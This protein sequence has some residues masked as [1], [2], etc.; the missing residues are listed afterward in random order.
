MYNI[1]TILAHP[2]KTQLR[3]MS[4]V[5]RNQSNGNAR[6]EIMAT[7]EDPENLYQSIF[8]F[9]PD[10]IIMDSNLLTPCINVLAGKCDIIIITEDRSFTDSSNIHCAYVP[11]QPPELVTQALNL[12]AIITEEDY[13]S[14]EAQIF[15][16]LRS[17]GLPQKYCS[18]IDA[19][20]YENRILTRNGVT[21]FAQRKRVLDSIANGSL[22]LERA[23]QKHIDTGFDPKASYN[24]SAMRLVED[25]GDIQAESIFAPVGNGQQF[26]APAQAPYAQP[27][28]QPSAPRQPSNIQPSVQ[29]QNTAQPTHASAQNPGQPRATAQNTPLLKQQVFDSM[30]ASGGIP[31]RECHGSTPGMQDI[32]PQ[33]GNDDP[34]VLSVNDE[35]HLEFLRSPTKTQYVVGEKIKREDLLVKLIEADGSFILV[36]D[37]ELSP[38]GTLTQEDKQVTIRY[39]GLVL[40]YPITVVDKMLLAVVINTMPKKLDYICGTKELDLSGGTLAVFFSDSTNTQIEITQDMIEGFDGNRIGRQIVNICYRDQKLPMQITIRP[41]NITK[42]E[43]ISQPSRRNYTE[44]ERLDTTGLVLCVTYDNDEK[45]YVTD[46]ECPEIK[47]QKDQAVVQ[48]DYKGHIFP[49]FVHVC[50][51]VLTG[52]RME[53]LP[54]KL[55]YLEKRD[56]LEVTGGQVARLMSNGEVEIVPLELRMVSGFNNQRVGKCRVAV[57]LDDFQCFFDVEIVGREVAKL[58]VVRKPHKTT[59][60]EQEPFEPE[61]MEIKAQYNNNTFERVEVYEYEPRVLDCGTTAVTIS[62]GGKT[63][64]VPVQVQ[65]RMVESISIA[66]MP[67]KMHFKEGR[68][69]LDVSGGKLLVIYNN[70]SADTIDMYE[71]MVEGFDN[72][73]AGDNLLTVRLQDKETQYHVVIDPKV[74]IGISIT[75][76]PDKV[77]YQKG[78]IPDLDGMKLLG[79]YDNSSMSEIQHYAYQPNGALQLDDTAIIVSYMD[80]VAIVPI[81][82]VEEI[83]APEPVIEAAP[84]E[85]EEEVLP[86]IPVEEPVVPTDSLSESSRETETDED[87]IDNLEI[88]IEPEEKNHIEP[89]LVIEADDPPLDVSV[90]EDSSE[91]KQDDEDISEDRAGEIESQDPVFDDEINQEADAETNEPQA[92]TR[93][94]RFYAGTGN[95]RFKSDEGN[96]RLFE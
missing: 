25:L 49:V 54:E 22:P 6:I 70:G 20:C 35:R 73:K 39:D 50:S 59:Y 32:L 56:M 15:A 89:E 81:T 21:P 58:E 12:F 51:C 31:L 44:G 61:G 18:A 4:G 96:Y 33:G 63:A 68:E 24:P 86:I 3:I 94:V 80:K 10:L 64:E 83:E 26:T 60:F 46:Y 17:L 29:A 36:R 95:L 79:F 48:M 66:K 78:D 84:I 45:E 74:L 38:S 62:F 8:R 9:A 23:K 14:R 40:S 87:S 82:V 52:I 91:T 90:P 19:F 75:K 34:A 57:N 41:K 11:V 53:T 47:V 43:V 30:G 28:N 77:T 67:D 85:P 65:M 7:C 27:G 13:K 71:D 2:D 1:K 93:G 55:T 92:K 5:I 42:V 76:M 16:Y 69:Q 88:M 37:F 72:M